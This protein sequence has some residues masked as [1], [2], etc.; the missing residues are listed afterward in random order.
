LKELDL[1]IKG[2]RYPFASIHSLIDLKGKMK[3]RT[4][5]GTISLRGWIDLKT[6]D[7][8]NSLEVLEMELDT[9]KPYY[10]RKVSA[11]IDSGHMNMDSEITVR[12]KRF[13]ALGKMDLVN[14][15]VK[16]GGTVFRIP[17]ETVASLLD[18]KKHQIRVPFHVKGNLEDPRFSLQETFL[19]QIAFSLAEGLG[20]PL[21]SV[22]ESVLG[23]T[24]K[25]TEGLVEG[26]KSIEEMF[27]KKKEKKRF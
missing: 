20:L 19:T 25:E 6:M 12:G 26:L 8:E 4:R 1:E 16:G 13:D 7:M 5:E 23:D 10:R 21:I 17:A 27:K 2:I 11:E 14:L 3:G 24:G 9:F 18:Q 15:H 22:G